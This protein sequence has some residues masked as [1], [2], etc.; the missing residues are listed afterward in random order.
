MGGGGQPNDLDDRELYGE[1]GQRLYDLDKAN[2]IRSSHENPQVQRLY[3]EFLVA[4]LGE[5]SH[6]LLHTDHKAWKMP[7]EG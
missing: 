4:P 3:Q 6:H 2:A 7:N 5:K 1:R